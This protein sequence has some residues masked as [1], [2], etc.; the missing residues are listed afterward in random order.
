MFKAGDKVRRIDGS[1][2]GMV[3]GDVGTVVSME[4]GRLVLQ[5]YGGSHSVEKFVLVHPEE[6]V[7]QSTLKNVQ[8]ALDTQV[9][10]DHY[11][12]LKIQ[13]VEYIMANEI[14]YM[15]GNV[16]KYVTRW[17]GKAGVQDLEK[18]KHYIEMLIEQE[19]KN[20]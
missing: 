15:E 6:F 5:E 14:P 16:I 11:K 18:A 9:G 2:M 19:K 8:Q 3:T 17:R 13:P 12:K 10:G 7:R 1:H 4:Y 20:A